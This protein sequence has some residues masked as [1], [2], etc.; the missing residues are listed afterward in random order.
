MAAIMIAM[1]IP[2]SSSSPPPADLP[3]SGFFVGASV[4]NAV[5]EWV[6]ICRVVG[7]PVGIAEGTAVGGTV[8]AATGFMV[9]WNEGAR[10]GT[11]V[12]ESDGA[13]VG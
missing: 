1:R 2:G 9:G 5:G 13:K 7:A 3:T 4:G 12:G 8:G 6:N 11:S 10:V